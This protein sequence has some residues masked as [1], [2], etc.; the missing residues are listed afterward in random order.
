[1]DTMGELSKLSRN[2]HLRGG[3]FSKGRWP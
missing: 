2:P 3:K 1:L